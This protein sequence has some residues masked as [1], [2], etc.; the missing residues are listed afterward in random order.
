MTAE[1][2]AYHGIERPDAIA[3]VSNGREIP[4]MELDRD[5]RAM[6]RALRELGLSRGHSVAIRSD[7]LYVHWLLLLAVW[8]SILREVWELCRCCHCHS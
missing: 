5:I 7:N 2:V 1:Y 4:Y 8:R 3:V 6:S